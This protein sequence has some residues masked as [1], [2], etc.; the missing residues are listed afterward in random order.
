MAAVTT[1]PTAN[2]AALTTNSITS[3]SP[4]KIISITR[5]SRVQ[6]SQKL[7]RKRL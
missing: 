1:V 4:L 2:M 7:T 5:K 3:N 6:H